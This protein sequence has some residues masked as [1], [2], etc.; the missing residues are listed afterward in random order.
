MVDFVEQTR[1]ML[2]RPSA[3]HRSAGRGQRGA[4]L[5]MLLCCCVLFQMLGVAA[6]L[7]DS[8]GFFD[9][10]E[11]S[12]LEGW[13]I[14]TPTPQWPAPSVVARLVDQPPVPCSRI[15]VRALFRPPLA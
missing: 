4:G 11:S 14:H 7:L 13:S 5:V 12:V 8:G 6:P 15:L 2:G 9:L 3:G 1:R 10:G